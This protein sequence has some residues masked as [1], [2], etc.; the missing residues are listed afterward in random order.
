MVS[1]LSSEPTYTDEVQ[2]SAPTE[3]LS[4]TVLLKFTGTATDNDE[5]SQQWL[6]V[7]FANSP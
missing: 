6:S 1:A 3:T 2:R 7:D 4:G 5:V